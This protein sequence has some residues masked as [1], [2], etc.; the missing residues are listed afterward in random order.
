MHAG[1]TAG[2]CGRHLAASTDWVGVMKPVAY[3]FKGRA[4]SSCVPDA[5]AENCVV[6]TLG[7]RDLAIFRV[8]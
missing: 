1:P 5:F 8:S 7:R 2:A 4:R 6:S 3:G